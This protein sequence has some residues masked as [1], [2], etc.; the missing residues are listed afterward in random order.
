MDSRNFSSL[1]CLGLTKISLQ[2]SLMHTVMHR[3]I[4]GLPLNMVYRKY[5]EISRVEIGIDITV[6]SFQKVAKIIFSLIFPQFL[7]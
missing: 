3:D 5:S 6:D 7:K 1:I 4:V 2:P